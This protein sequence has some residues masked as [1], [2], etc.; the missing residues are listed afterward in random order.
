VANFHLVGS[1]RGYTQSQDTELRSASNGLLGLIVSEIVNEQGNFKQ[2]MR[3]SL[4][5]SGVIA[6]VISTIVFGVTPSPRAAQADESVNLQSFQLFAGHRGGT[7]NTH[8]AMPTGTARNVFYKSD[9]EVFE[10]VRYT[11][12]GGED[13]FFICDTMPNGQQEG[14]DFCDVG[15]SDD[16]GRCASWMPIDKDA[17]K[18]P[19]KWT[20]NVVLNNATVVGQGETVASKT[21]TLLNYDRPKVSHR[22]SNPNHSSARRGQNNGPLTRLP[23]SISGR[24]LLRSWIRTAGAFTFHYTYA[25]CWPNSQGN[26][27]EF[28]FKLP[29]DRRWRGDRIYVAQ[30]PLISSGSLH[31]SNANGRTDFVV[32]AA[33][34][35][36][37]LDVNCVFK[38]KVTKG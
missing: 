28:W 11:Y 5:W 32:L 25:G 38:L 35:D 3:E 22:S 19:G 29:Q 30:G 4:R 21:F 8:L 20:V 23:W 1:S 2:D 33:N 37:S 31:F 9:R 17:L 26:N 34:D 18:Y 10:F 12:S 14:C 16:P 13:E 15:F 24:T 36:Y 27:L 6:T 7:T